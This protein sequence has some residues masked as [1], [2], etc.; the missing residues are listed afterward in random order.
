MAERKHGDGCHGCKWHANCGNEG[1]CL[2]CFK[3][4]EARGCPPGKGC[5]RYK[6]VSNAQRLRDYLGEF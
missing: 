2:F 5:K 6:K 1:S 3:T 4:G